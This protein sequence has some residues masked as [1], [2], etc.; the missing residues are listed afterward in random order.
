M[1]ANSR[2]RSA[3]SCLRNPRPPTSA[4]SR[5]ATAPRRRRLGAHRYGA[6]AP[7]PLNHFG[8]GG[9][10]HQP[11]L[12]LA[13]RP[14]RR[15][16]EAVMLRNPPERC[17]SLPRSSSR[18]PGRQPARNRTS[19][20][21][22]RDRG[23]LD[24]GVVGTLKDQAL[25]RRLQSQ[26]LSNGRAS[27]ISGLTAVRAAD[28]LIQPHFR[29]LAAAPDGIVGSVPAGA[30]D[31]PGGSPGTAGAPAAAPGRRQDGGQQVVLHA[32]VEQPGDRGGGA[33]W[34]AAWT[35]RGGRSARPAWR[36]ARSRRS[37]ISPT[38]M[39]SGSWRRIERSR[40]AKVRPI[41]G[42][43]LDLVDAAELVL[44]RVLDGDDLA[45]RPC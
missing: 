39:T 23:A 30:G 14:D 12:D 20:H 28:R 21:A 19:R 45:R 22:A 17:V 13:T 32:H 38:M 9:G 44:D 36:S 7:Q 10:L 40:L 6:L 1:M 35:A 8:F 29:P 26:E 33:C 24:A 15:V 2:T 5:S 27:A 43:H 18:P 34:C 16:A 31:R 41:C 37:R 4:C 3:T 25:D 42:L 11:T